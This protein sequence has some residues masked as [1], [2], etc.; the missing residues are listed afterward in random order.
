MKTEKHMQTILKDAFSP[1]DGQIAAMEQNILNAVQPCSTEPAKSSLRFRVPAKAVLAAAMVVVLSV[2]GISAVP[3]I[4]QFFFPGAGVVEI[5]S[6]DEPLYMILDTET[7]ADADYEILYGYWYDDKAAVHIQSMTRYENLD[8]A[9]LFDTENVSL[10]LEGV[11]FTYDL[12]V[13]ENIVSGQEYRIVLDSLSYT[14]IQNGIRFGNTLL[15]FDRMPVDYHPYIKEENGLRLTLIPMTLDYTLFA[16][17]IAYTDR[18]GSLTLQT[19]SHYLSGHNASAMY[20]ID[21]D[22]KMYPLQ[23]DRNSI[24]YRIEESPSA[25]I[26]GFRAEQLIF[27]RDF[28]KNNQETLVTVSL[29]VQGE[30]AVINQPFSFPDGVVGNIYAVGYDNAILEEQYI[31]KESEFPLGYLSVITEAVERNGIRY[32]FELFYTDEYTA[33]LNQFT[34]EEARDPYSVSPMTPLSPKSRISLIGLENMV[35]HTEHYVSDG[36]DSVV[37]KADSYTGI[38]AGEWDIDFSGT[39]G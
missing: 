32:W 15:H 38:A 21:A 33:Y 29:P 16:A 28:T 34:V 31:D 14:E 10:T 2:T 25:P 13:E 20:L 30:A 17:E 19:K 8:P 7:E 22:G 37:L 35:H 12:D 18:E 5:E 36:Q 26:V 1:D 4:R 23:Q 6:A 27:N 39:A 3:S 11:N 9:S 24:F